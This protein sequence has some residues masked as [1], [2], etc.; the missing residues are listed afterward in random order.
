MEEL[1]ARLKRRLP[2]WKD[3]ELL[4]DLLEDAKAF[5][6]AYTSRDEMPEALENVQVAIATILFNRMGME[7]EIRH[8]E[9]SADRTVEAIPEDIRRQLN[10]YRRVRTVQ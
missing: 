3:E 6:L 4:Q 9:G 2:D 5:I 7:G 1:L 8:G 10:P